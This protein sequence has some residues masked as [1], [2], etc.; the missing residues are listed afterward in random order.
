MG[1][2]SRTK[3]NVVAKLKN[4]GTPTYA[5][6]VLAAALMFSA[7]TRERIVEGVDNSL[8]QQPQEPVVM[9]ADAPSPTPTETL[10]PEP[11]ETPPPTV[12][13][14]EVQP[15]DSIIAVAE[16]FG[17]TPQRLRALNLLTTDALQVGQVLRVPYV[18]GVT[19]PLGIP[20]ATPEPL[21]Y[22]VEQ[23]DTLLSIALRF[24]VSL[25]AIMDMN[26]LQDEHNLLVG[27]VLLVP[28][29]SS[30]NQSGA[31]TARVD[32]DLARQAGTHTVQPGETLAQIAETYGI[33]LP[34]LIASNNNT[35]TNPHV[36][37]P[38]TVLNIPGFN[39]ADIRA[40]NQTYYTV[41]DGDSLFA[42]SQR[43]G[44]S[45]EALMAANNISNADL[46]RVGDEL[47]IP[48]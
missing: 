35:I 17:A 48:E 25:G 26:S 20:T 1:T 31:G 42:I 15:G 18:E 4:S 19:T 22:T 38:N 21:Q 7:C 43:F 36:L 33:S 8:G 37:T 40:L 45:A 28:G 39:A 6:L 34:D 14:Y 2:Y 27:Q 24:D 3:S 47:V 5:M 30:V 16:K 13:T 12:T 32:S 11:T 9:Q 10:T 46:L 23:G 44:V 29:A 41:Q